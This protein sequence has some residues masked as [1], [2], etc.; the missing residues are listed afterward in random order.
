VFALLALPAIAHADT[1]FMLVGSAA[2]SFDH[3][4]LVR[5]GGKSWVS[6]AAVGLL[7]R[8]KRFAAAELL[9][10]GSAKY[11]ALSAAE[12]EG[13]RLSYNPLHNLL[14]LSGKVGRLDYDSAKGTLHLGC[15]TPISVTGQINEGDP[16]LLEFTIEGGWMPEAP[17]RDYPADPLVTRLSFKSQPELGRTFVFARQPARIG[18][19]IVRDERAARAGE[20]GSPQGQADRS[21]AEV[22]IHFGNFIELTDLRKSA[23][24]EM[25]VTLE[26]GSRSEAKAQLLSG[27]PRLVVDFAGA[28]VDGTA[29]SYKPQGRATSVRL[30]NGPAGARLTIG[31]PGRLDWRILRGDGGARQQVQLLPY[32]AGG[33]NPR[34]GRTILLDAGHG[35]VDDGATG[36]VGGVKEKDLNLDITDKL[37]ANLRTLGYNVLLTRPEDRFVSLGSRGDYANLLLP[38]VFVSVHCN[39]Y[40]AEHQGVITFVHPAAGEDSRRLAQLVDSEFVA[41]TGAVDKGVHEEDFFVLRET[42]IPSILVECGFMTHTEEC[43]RLCDPAYQQKIA[44]GIARGID[45]YVLG[46]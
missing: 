29:R 38:W 19:S 9:E 6:G 24:G 43:G 36:V 5:S 12:R 7:D 27:P 8:D 39:S 40:T 23:S 41:A 34:A 33:G 26:L 20:P 42:V 44:D 4:P 2:R 11:V 18:F 13:Y 3:P 14:Q 45:R 1:Y 21:A 28:K 32:A 35:G 22:G 31:L 37:A 10:G 25:A 30:E 15:L 17:P 16:A 46:E